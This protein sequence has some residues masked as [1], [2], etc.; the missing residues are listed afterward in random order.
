MKHVVELLVDFFAAE[1]A[2][3]LG[4][5]RLDGEHVAVNLV[6]EVV[7]KLGTRTMAV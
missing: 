6:E 1:S 3:F 2:S 5:V 4:I 7:D